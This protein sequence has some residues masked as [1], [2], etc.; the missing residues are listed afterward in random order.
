MALE[1]PSENSGARIIEY[2]YGAR[3]HYGRPDIT[4]YS[5]TGEVEYRDGAAA[6]RFMSIFIPTSY[7]HI[8]MSENL[9]TDERPHRS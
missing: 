1:A 3:F 5:A 6:S 9:A 8:V 2:E 7:T 4:L